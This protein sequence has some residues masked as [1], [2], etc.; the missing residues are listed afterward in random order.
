MYCN[1]LKVMN[2]NAADEGASEWFSS[3]FD[4]NAGEPRRR[5]PTFCKAVGELHRPIAV[6]FAAQ[7]DDIEIYCG[8][9]KIREIGKKYTS[10]LPH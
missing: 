2:W 1:I 4:D 3:V 6:S 9:A 5:A 10:F 7:E 8:H